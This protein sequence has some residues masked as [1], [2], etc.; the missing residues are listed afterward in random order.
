M[1][2]KMSNH[3][4]QG[5]SFKEYV[6]ANLLWKVYKSMAFECYY[7]MLQ[8]EQFDIKWSGEDWPSWWWAMNINFTLMHIW[9]LPIEG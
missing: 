3:V 8:Q 7:E 1:R 4:H 6:E 9:T 2:S 5:R